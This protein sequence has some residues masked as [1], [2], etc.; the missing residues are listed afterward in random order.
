M[1]GAPVVIA[2]PARAD[3]PT[4][5]IELPDTA[6]YGQDL[7]ATARVVD[8][9]SQP[10]GS[11]IVQFNYRTSED[12]ETWIPIG[13]PVAI[14]SAGVAVSPPVE[15]AD[16]TPLPVTSSSEYYQVQAVYNP[17]EPDESSI[18]RDLTIG[19]SGTSVTIL[20][21]A[22]NVVAALSG[23]QPGGVLAGSIRPSGTVAFT[24][25]GQAQA[26]VPV[27]PQTGRATLAVAL[28]AGATVTASYDGDDRYLA[29]ATSYTRIDPVVSARIQSKS[30]PSKSGWY[31]NPVEISFSCSSPSSPSSQVVDCPVGVLLGTSGKNQTLTRIVHAAD[32][33]TA[34]I[35]VTGINID[36]DR[37]KIT[38]TGRSC[39][40][41]DKLSGVK[42]GCRIEVDRT[43]RY[44][45]TA[46]DR[47]GNK[48]VK[49]GYLGGTSVRH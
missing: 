12:M 32:G 8:E 39:R 27:D 28:S 5:T 37:P 42:G 29:G 19:R 44:K 20:P 14:S 23:A 10:V 13:T 43:G 11:G 22:T 7:R 49:Y 26:P 41:T 33:G 40:A 6:A 34:T 48:K 18:M 15:Q 24:I 3:V 2:A 21:S 25:N 9:A 4:T 46:T 47:A 17:G 1:V 35:T 38:V 36:R 16:Q 31:R 45:A 30:K